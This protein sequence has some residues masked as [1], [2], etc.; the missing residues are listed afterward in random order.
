MHDDA[1]LMTRSIPLL[2]LLLTTSPVMADEIRPADLPAGIVMTRLDNYLL[3]Q[4]KTVLTIN[5]ENKGVQDKYNKD[6]LLVSHISG[7]A[8]LQAADEE[9]YKLDL[10]RGRLQE[11][12]YAPTAHGGF[13]NHNMKVL[14]TDDDGRAI[15][16]GRKVAAEGSP[17][18]LIN[19]K[20]DTS[21]TIISYQ[22]GKQRH[23]IYLNRTLQSA[24]VFEFSENGRRQRQHC[25][26]NC[27]DKSIREFGPFGPTR[28]LS[29][30]VETLFSYENGTLVSIITSRKDGG[31]IVSARFF[32]KYL[33]D[34]CGNWTYRES[35]G[36]IDS[37]VSPGLNL[38][39]KRKIEYFK[40]CP[41][42]ARP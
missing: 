24:E 32:E 12:M 14:K 7:T 15:A 17:R 20:A 6:G 40:D 38:R 25:V 31:D 16:M 19:D 26:E 1:T 35:R 3:G 18:S 28:I 21:V 30:A 8:G 10:V 23:E 39:E 11:V 9:S 5:S 13:N 41:P 34:D 42:A 27:S 29:D 4:P 33:F 2:F 37:A 22:P 36:S